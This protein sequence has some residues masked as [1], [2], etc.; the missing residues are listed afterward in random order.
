MISKAGRNIKVRLELVGA[1][2]VAVTW[3]SSS[4]GQ[5]LVVVSSKPKLLS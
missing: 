5:C 2:G 1:T 3:N 4:N